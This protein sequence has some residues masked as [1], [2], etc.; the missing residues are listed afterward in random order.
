MSDRYKSSEE[1][2]QKYAR[3]AAQRNALYDA[4]LTKEQRDAEDASLE[5]WG[6]Q[7]MIEGMAQQVVEERIAA[8]EENRQNNESRQRY[9]AGLS[10]EQISAV[11]HQNNGRLPDSLKIEGTLIVPGVFADPLKKGIYYD[12]AGKI[13]S[14]LEAQARIQRKVTEEVELDQQTQAT[15]EELKEK[16]PN[17]DP[18]KKYL[19]N[20]QALMFN[21]MFEKFG[22][23]EDIDFSGPEK[24]YR[25]PK[26]IA[27]GGSF[28]QRIST[29]ELFSPTEGTFLQATPAQLGS[30]IPML[31]FFIV[32]KDGYQEEIY[33]SDKTSVG[34]IK[35]LAELKGKSIEDIITYNSR[36]GGEAGIK[37]FSW[38]YNNKHEGDYIIEADLE[39]YF[40]SLVELANDEYLKFLFP[41]GEE[42]SLA[43]DISKTADK[44]RKS[45]N[46]K[47]TTTQQGVLSQALGKLDEKI[48]SYKLLENG[49][50]NLGEI[51]SK[52]EPKKRDNFRQLKVVVGWSLPEGNETQ[53]QSLFPG[54]KGLAGFREE[55]KKT[56]T[57]I[58]LNLIDYNVDFSQE[59]P[60]TLK[61]KYLGSSDNYLAKEKS[62]I[63]GSNN[64]KS[65]IMR[66]DTQVS[67]EGILQQNNTL[68]DGTKN[69]KTN[70]KS[71]IN[72][73]KIVQQDPYLKA[74]SQASR[75]DKDIFGERYAVVQLVGLKLAQELV[76]LELR[77]EE[78]KQTD[79]EDPIFKKLRRRGQMLVLLYQRALEIRLRD[80]YSAFLDQMLDDQMV[81][82]ALV[83]LVNNSA[84]DYSIKVTTDP[85]RVATR[86]TVSQSIQKAERILEDLKK[87]KGLFGDVLRYVDKA[88]KKSAP[89]NNNP[90]PNEDNRSFEVYYL[91]LGDILRLMMRNADLRD[92]I[93][94]LLGN[95]EDINENI[96][97]IYKIPITLES[98]GEFFYNRIVAQKL[99]SYPYRTFMNDFLNYTARLMNQNPQ[100]SE[101]ISFDYTV[102]P[103]TYRNIQVGPSRIL[104]GNHIKGIREKFQDPLSNTFQ[105]AKYE[106]YYAI[107]VKKTSFGKRV[108]NYEADKKDG[109]FH[110]MLGSDR[111]LAKQFN[112]SRQETQ[113]FQEMLIESNNPS[114]KIQAL[115]LP[116]N[117]D[118]EM[119]GNG[120]HRNGDLIFVDTRA[121]LGDFAS[122]ILGIGGYYRVVRS[123]HKI[124]NRGYKTTLNCVFEL[125]AGRKK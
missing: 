116:Q 58:L 120:I 20:T 6:R 101:R 33:F 2:F 118:I 79:P 17:P 98:F 44:V 82:I 31:R 124:T 39:L 93:T 67:L 45:E 7:T 25:V 37:A 68:S 89:K 21:K 65:K 49:N 97:S 111:G 105:R 72:P 64:F 113:Y 12:G 41:T 18:L 52:L 112:F 96:Y 51:V 5:A 71:G 14:P 117:V 59:G 74:V 87:K 55:V 115:F 81:K 50:K 48:D 114:D 15:K 77:R 63:F 38:N 8:A 29:Q 73:L 19:K 109:I 57:A 100:T 4:S 104:Q 26:N 9:L 36:G 125:R 88:A 24:I 60:T 91:F 1:F 10:R 122:Q 27:K 30:L 61:L 28:T 3:E 102:F 35:A 108:G 86:Q 42:T 66:K 121:A 85:K 43:T 16:S 11:A 123:S 76:T 70:S 46:S 40:G 106:S 119:Y 84:G 34:H 69:A 47:Y 53:L 32:D 78:A 110:Y 92:D 83:D 13:L 103:S 99:T 23:T 75:G 22:N 54:K 80:M 56:H 62:D 107:Y 95:F 94:F 90:P